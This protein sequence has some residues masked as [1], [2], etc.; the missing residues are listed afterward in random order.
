M[1]VVVLLTSEEGDFRGALVEKPLVQLFVGKGDETRT[2][3]RTTLPTE[4]DRQQT[5]RERR[6]IS[7]CI[8]LDLRL[9]SSTAENHT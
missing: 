6:I 7:D 2:V 4:M 8:A 1:V 9:W 5:R 3:D